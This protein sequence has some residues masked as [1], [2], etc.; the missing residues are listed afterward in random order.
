MDI[1]SKYDM[2]IYL[3][4]RLWVDCFQTR[5]DRTFGYEIVGYALTELEA[6]DWIDRQEQKDYTVDDCWS[7]KGTM[8][9]F[10]WERVEWI[11]K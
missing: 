7:I 1:A 10:V 3:L 8:K 5:E 2:G 9:E 4:K 11:N 6:E